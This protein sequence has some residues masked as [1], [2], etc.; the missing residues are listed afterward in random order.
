MLTLDVDVAYRVATSKDLD[1]LLQLVEEF[2]QFENLPFD[3]VLDRVSLQLFLSNPSMGKVWLIC[4]H[5]ALAP[6]KRDQVI[7]YIAVTFSYSIEFRG[8]GACVDEVYLRASHRG[9][10]I[11]TKTLKFVEGAC[12][13][14][15][16]SALSL[17]VHEDNKR[18]KQ[19]YQKVG[20]DDRGYRLMMKTIA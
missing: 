10:G 9:K 2:H 16:I 15:G 1:V 17:V 8:I 3:P 13:A 14:M 18:A 7:G 20:Y 4:D 5:N 19:V 11:G 6:T 12:R